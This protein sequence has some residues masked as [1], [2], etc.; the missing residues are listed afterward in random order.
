MTN[1][2]ERRHSRFTASAVDMAPGTYPEIDVPFVSGNH[3]G[4]TVTVPSFTTSAWSTGAGGMDLDRRQHLVCADN[5]L[6]H[7][8]N[9]AQWRNTNGSDSSIALAFRNMTSAGPTG[10]VARNQTTL[11]PDN[12]SLF[13]DGV[14]GDRSTPATSPGDPANLLAARRWVRSA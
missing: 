4:G 12:G 1:T 5:G 13:P 6:E 9:Q 2:T 8:G 3:T 11:G 7:A 14:Q 10:S